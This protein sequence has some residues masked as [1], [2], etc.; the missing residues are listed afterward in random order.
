MN[1]LNSAGKMFRHYKQG[2]SLKGRLLESL[3][4]RRLLT[5]EVA[6]RDSGSVLPFFD[7]P[8]LTQQD[9]RLQQLFDSSYACALE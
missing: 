4:R 8:C 1:K 6:Q 9:E 5:F 7:L 3:A 2:G